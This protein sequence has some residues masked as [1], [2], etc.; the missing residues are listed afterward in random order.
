MKKDT[1]LFKKTL[2]DDLLPLISVIIPSRVGEKII[3]I[4]TLETQTYKNIEIIIEYDKKQEGASV[5]RNRGA[6]KAKGKYLFFCDNDLELEPDALENL[7][8]TAKKT[9]AKWV[10]GKFWIEGEGLYNDKKSLAVPK[11][12]KSVKFIEWF[13]GIST[14]SLIDASIKP[15]F[16]ENFRKFNDWDLWL[17]IYKKGY[18]PAFCDKVLFKTSFKPGGI[19]LS[20]DAE[21]WQEK[22]YIKHGIHSYEDALRLKTSQIG[23]YKMALNKSREEI[24]HKNNEIKNIVNE[25]KNI[26]HEKNH[27]IT[28]Y[29]RIIKHKNKQIED[30]KKQIEDYARIV[31]HRD[32]QINAMSSSMRWKIPD[33]FYKLYKFRI[34]QF[35]PKHAGKL[36]KKGL[37]ILKKDGLISFSKSLLEYILFGKGVLRLSDESEIISY[38]DY[39]RWIQINEQSIQENINEIINQIEYKPKISL[40][41][42]VHDPNE[43]FLR[44]TIFSVIHQS[45]PNWELCIVNNGSSN[46][47]IKKILTD[48]EKKDK[49]I[50]V[51]YLE[52]KEGNNTVF[53]K[54]MEMADGEFIGFLNQEDEL[55]LNALYENIRFLDENKKI[56]LIYSD[57]DKINENYVRSDYNFKPDW[58]PELL[59]SYN[60]LGNFRLI[61]KSLLSYTNDNLGAD[62]RSFQDYNLLLRIAEKTNRIGHITKVLYHKRIYHDPVYAYKKETEDK[63][64]KKLESGK[65]ALKSALLR[66]NIKGTVINPRFALKNDLEIFK[67][68]FDSVYYKD[69]VTIVIPT[70]DRVDLLKN[71]INSIRKKTNYKNYNILI[72]NNNSTEQKTFEFFKKEK[73]KY[74]NIPTDNF[75]FAKIHNIAINK[76]KSELVLLLNNDTKVISPNWLLEMVGTISLDKKIGAVGA[77]LIYKDK[78]VQHAGVILGLGYTAG[79]ANRMIQFNEEGYQNYNLVMRNYSAVTAACMLTKKSLYQKVGGMDE[80]RLAVQFNDVDYCLKLLTRGYRVVYNP[81]VLLYHFERKSRGDNFDM[82]EPEYFAKKWIHLTRQDPFYNP[83]LSLANGRFEIN[84]NWQ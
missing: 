25:T 60:Y 75:N 23:N 64:Y 79:E 47:I 68:K 42:S 48:F 2:K 9:G 40:F 36:F 22:L 6:R 58:S 20:D 84:R 69:K 77:R 52:N 3:S 57:E 46:K 59:I 66:R 76:I 43:I 53:K 41:L 44:K 14:M 51:L 8:I 35:R 7:F 27:R 67:I 78:K 33:Y 55:S 29:S 61:R 56:N 73:L 37:L 63:I 62:D 49:R 13:R 28:E 4:K 12:E 17:T 71:C 72:I 38:S 21:F 11:N 19:S 26:L 15:I 18:K 83:N 5:V 74:I 39:E 45:Y 1:P 54:T 31:Y 32:L 34:K 65:L 24:I 16:D 70:K 82:K 30:Y 80:K 81:D 10:F 50:K